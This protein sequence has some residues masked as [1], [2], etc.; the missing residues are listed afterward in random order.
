SSRPKRKRISPD[1]FQALSDIFEHTDTPNFEL[2]EQ[3][4][5]R[6]NMT[7]REV[8]VWFQNRRAKFN[9][10]RQQ[11]LQAPQDHPSYSDDTYSSTSTS[12]SPSFTPISSPYPALSPEMTPLDILALAARYVERCDQ[13]QE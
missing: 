2:R 7:N 6:L 5:L 1:Q 12:S 13:E 9:R 8:Q 3:L 4:A 10:V 11:E